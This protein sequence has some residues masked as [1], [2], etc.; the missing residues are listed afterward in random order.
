MSAGIDDIDAT[1]MLALAGLVRVTAGAGAPAVSVERWVGELPRAETVTQETFARAPALLLAFGG[2]TATVDVRTLAGG[3][4]VLATSTWEVLVVVQEPRGATPTLKGAGAQA[5]AY[6]LATRVA[7][8]GNGL[9]VPAPAATLTFTVTGTPSA[10]VPLGASVLVFGADPGA[11]RFRPVAPTATSVTL[12]GLGV[13]TVTAAC[14]TAGAL[15]NLTD[16][17]PVVWSPVPAGLAAPALVAST[18]T[19]GRDGLERSRA[20]EYV[21]TRFVGVLPGRIVVLGVRFAALRAVPIT[22]LYDPTTC[23]PDDE[24]GVPYLTTD[25]NVD[26]HDDPNGPYLDNPTSEFTADT[27]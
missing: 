20:L 14:A 3:L 19:P 9:R 1:L 27:T 11:V 7:Q 17:W 6:A 15:G 21:G 23:A 18:V 16:A 22:D 24:S 13:G 12:D 4:D 25:G 8:R 5:G 10:V 26:T 2:E